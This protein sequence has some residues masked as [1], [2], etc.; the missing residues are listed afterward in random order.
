MEEKIIIWLQSFSNNFYD[1]FFQSVSYLVSW[2][3]A[4]CLFLVVLLFLDKKYALCMGFGYLITVIFNYI[5]KVIIARPRP[6]VNNPQIINKLTTIGQS[7]PS[8]HSVSVMF[9]VLALLSLFAF[10]CKKGKMEIYKKTWF[11]ILSYSVAIVLVL[12][13]AIAR[14]YLGQHYISDIIVGLIIGMFGFV[15]SYFVF[16]KIATKQKK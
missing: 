5:L 13:T 14:M 15:V 6:Y 8:G 10:L 4:F 12:L 2:I 1:L 9:I 7:F 16:K 11:K 3:G